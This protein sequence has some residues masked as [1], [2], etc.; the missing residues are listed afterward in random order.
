MAHKLL[1]L[2]ESLYK[3]PLLIT[4]QLE[5]TI[6]SYLSERNNGEILQELSV[7]QQLEKASG[8]LG[9][10]SEGGVGVLSVDGPLTYQT[11]GFE[12]LCGGTSYQSLLEQAKQLGADPSVSS[13]V[14]DVD[15]GGGQAYSVFESANDIKAA[16]NGKPLIAYVDG[17]SASAAYALSSVAD[18]IIVNPMA[19]VGSI[20]VVVRM[21]NDSEKKK[22]EGVKDVYVYAG[23]S[24]I[25]YAEDGEFR[26]DFIS[27]IQSKV[28]VLYE[29]FVSH[30]AEARNISAE[31]VRGTQAKTFE[32]NKAIELGLAESIEA[33]KEEAEEKLNASVEANSEMFQEVA[34]KADEEALA[35]SIDA[36]KDAIAAK[37]IAFGNKKSK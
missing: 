13:V 29:E 15:S 24:K 23:D 8:S 21:Q 10:T 14:M 27:D 36:R 28:D 18:E 7:A 37:M 22:M 34:A 25:P 12:P 11:T 26:E 20:G 5:E 32:A 2:T 16:L 9:A 17:T 35:D 19:E 30:V 31:V 4:P 33:S 6:Y 1:R 3:D